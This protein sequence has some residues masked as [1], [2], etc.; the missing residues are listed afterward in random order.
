MLGIPIFLDL[1]LSLHDISTKLY[2][3]N[4]EL[5]TLIC[6]GIITNVISWKQINSDLTGIFA[7]KK[8][9]EARVLEIHTILFYF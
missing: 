1:S 6:D 8:Y 4:D 7:N 3:P 9:G 2:I 5:S